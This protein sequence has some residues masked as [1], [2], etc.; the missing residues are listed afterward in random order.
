MIYFSGEEPIRLFVIE[1]ASVMNAHAE[2]VC[3]CGTFLS[4]CI[5]SLRVEGATDTVVVEGTI[6]RSGL[7]CIQNGCAP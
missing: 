2:R 6:S 7:I 5:A 1:S 4:K 3:V